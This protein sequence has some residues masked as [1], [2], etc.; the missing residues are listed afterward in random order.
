ML[1][2][3]LTSAGGLMLCWGLGAT[4][5]AV[6][7][8]LRS[9]LR[10]WQ[11]RPMRWLVET[12]HL[13]GWFTATS[14]IGQLQIQVVGFLVAGQLS[15]DALA[16]LRTGQLVLIQ[17]V[18]N[19]IQ[20]VQG[21]V[22]PRESRLA[23]DAARLPGTEGEQAAV[24]FR[25]LTR[26]LALGFVGL[27]ALTVAVAWPLATLIVPH[28]HKFAGI[29]PL[30]L[31]LSLQAAIYLVQLPF[32]AG[33]RAMQRARLLFAQYALFTT[34]S[35]TALVIGASTS[36]LRGAAWGLNIGGA[37]GLAVSIAL[38]FWAL[39]RLGDDEPDRYEEASAAEPAT[40]P[41]TS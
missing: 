27:G 19:F 29:G 14:L 11:G 41:I 28:I 26:N 10:P 32:T 35:L 20:A 12:R 2:A 21:L 22:V 4:V 30:I 40:E 9:G 38:Y 25:R 8:L 31:P 17:P 33:L 23:R 7:F 13:S 6:V 36:G 5:G 1:G 24:A 39:R 34:A 15:K 18:Q 3:G 16:L 37:V